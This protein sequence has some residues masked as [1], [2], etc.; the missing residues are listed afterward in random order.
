MGPLT[1]WRVWHESLKAAAESDLAIRVK[2]EHPTWSAD[3]IPDDAKRETAA[4]SDSLA[5]CFTER[6][7]FRR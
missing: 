2:A 1:T 6:S 3:R 4:Q 7:P 5:Q